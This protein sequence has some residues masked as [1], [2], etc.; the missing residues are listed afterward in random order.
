VSDDI[1]NE[2][3]MLTAPF[4]LEYSY[5]RTTG[6]VIGDF[7]TALR[8]DAKILAARTPSG[9][10]VCPP[11]EYDPTSGEAIEELVEVGPGGVVTTWTWVDSPE[12]SHPHDQPF[13]FALV[14]LDGADTAMLH[15]VC[16]DSVDH[17]SSGM[18]VRARFRDERVGYITDIACF[19]A[20][21]AS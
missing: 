6:P 10:V 16:V 5:K 9:R 7:L 12:P 15:T 3:G 17:M 11:L 18:R 21:V 4:V 8:D 14:R 1:R 13:A 20:E 2:G 19:E